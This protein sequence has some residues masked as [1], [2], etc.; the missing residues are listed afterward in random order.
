MED[1]VRYLSV[2]QLAEL[3]LGSGEKAL[4]LA[5][6]CRSQPYEPF[7]PLIEPLFDFDRFFSTYRESPLFALAS[8]RGKSL[9]TIISSFNLDRYI[10][11]SVST[12][13]APPKPDPAM[14]MMCCEYFGIGPERSLFVGDAPTDREA[15]ERAGIPFLFFDMHVDISPVTLIREALVGKTA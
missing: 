14:L 8:N 7:V 2:S 15:A 3:L 4:E 1:Q 6:F 13:E 5:D 12:M 10:T 11:F 9:K